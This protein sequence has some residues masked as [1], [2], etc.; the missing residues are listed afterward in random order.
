MV[1]GVKMNSWWLEIKIE[2][3][4]KKVKELQEKA[5]NQI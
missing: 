3:Y 5:C 1:R 4:K 2:E